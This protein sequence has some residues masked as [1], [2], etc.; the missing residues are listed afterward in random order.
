[1]ASPSLLSSSCHQATL[2]NSSGQGRPLCTGHGQENSQRQELLSLPRKQRLCTLVCHHRDT[3]ELKM[4]SHNGLLISCRGKYFVSPQLSS[5]LALS[6]AL[7]FL[8]IVSWHLLGTTAQ[9]SCS[10]VAFSCGLF[11]PLMGKLV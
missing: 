8:P 6:P 3:G 1:M 2:T 11:L 7:D 10:R 4:K 5:Y 9:G